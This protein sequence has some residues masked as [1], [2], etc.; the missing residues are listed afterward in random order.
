[1]SN[2]RE[3]AQIPST[4]SGRRNLIING[5]MQVAQRG[6]S[7]SGKT[8]GGYYATD[9]WG[10][11]IDNMGTWTISQETDAPDGSG[12]TNSTKFL[13]T[14]ADAS[15]ASGDASI[16]FTRFE[17]QDLQFLEKGTS[18]A[19][20]VT[21]SFW[22][23]SSTT[24]TYILE[25]YDNDNARHINKSYTINSSA[26]WE[27]KEITFAGDTNSGD[28]FGNDA[29]LSLIV[30]WWL[31]A[32]SA[33]QSGTLATSWQE[34]ATADRVVGQV[35]VAGANNNYFQVT[36]V[37]LEVGS[38]ATEFEH[39]SFGEELALCQ[40]Y[41]YRAADGSIDTDEAGLG[42]C[43]A[44]SDGEY[45]S[46][47]QFPVQMRDIPSLDSPTVT[48][49]YR[50]VT[51]ASSTSTSQVVDSIT[52]AYPN[53]NNKRRCLITSGTGQPDLNA[54]GK[55]GYFQIYNSTTA[56]VAFDAEL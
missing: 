24:G 15:P 6:T 41:Y 21:V 1:M 51:G 14:T 19:K 16:C 49:G 23:K 28:T 22:V 8:S 5:A 32:G 52:I 50:F 7:S 46:A 33:Y 9:R 38:V 43:Y 2:A 27:K 12:L 25:L 4:P 35:N 29:N 39:R 56:Y 30:N 34:Y 37:Q 26:T 17:G 42:L 31:G 3:L 10:I 11:T 55:S 45:R 18:A 44:H 54:G 47:I 36:G 20:S 53:W 13:C 48:D 40:R